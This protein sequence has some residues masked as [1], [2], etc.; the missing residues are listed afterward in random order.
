MVTKG[1]LLVGHGSTMPYNKELIE[2]TGKMIAAQT[3]EFVVKCSFMNINKPSIKDALADFRKEKIDVLVVVPLFLAKGVHIE[4]DIPSEIGLPEG[5]K[6]GTFVLNGKIHPARVRRPHRDRP[7]ACRADGKKRKQGTHA[8]LILIC[9]SWYSIRS[10]AAA[11]S[12]QRLPGLAAPSTWWTC[13]GIRHRKLQNGQHHETYDLVVAPVHLDPAHPLL[14]GRSASEPVISHHEAVRQLLLGHVPQ[15]MIEITGAQGKTTT[16]YALAYLLPGPG[17]LHTSTGTYTMPG[18]TPLFKKSITPA[19]VLAA[20]EKAES[21]NG[22]LIAEE[23]LGV[24]GAGDLTIITSPSDYRFAAGKKSALAEK[25]ASVQKSR[26]L[27]H[28]PRHSAHGT[29]GCRA[30]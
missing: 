1:M 14:A 19:S 23:S 22:W 29:Y 5:T 10:M 20:A 13:T 24:T 15:P 26:R 30:A 25:I 21:L 6:K 28:S 16:A 7:V 8:Y 11:R 3:T 18:R 12:A 2:A 17:V 4:K 27:L 9:G